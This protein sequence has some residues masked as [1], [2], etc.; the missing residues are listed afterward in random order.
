MALGATEITVLQEDFAGSAVPAQGKSPELALVQDGERGQ[1]LKITRIDKTH[2]AIKLPMT[3]PIPSGHDSIVSFDYKGAGYATILNAAMQQIAGLAFSEQGQVSILST[4]KDTWRKTAMRIPIE[5]WFKV[6]VIFSAAYGS[7][8]LQFTTADGKTLES[9]FAAMISKDAPAFVQ[10]GNTYP[11]GT[12]SYADNVLAT[13]TEE[14]AP[15]AVSEKL[16]VPDGEVLL[17]AA[18]F[19]DGVVPGDGQPPDISIAEMPGKGRVLKFH[20]ST[21]VHNSTLIPLSQPVPKGHDFTLSLDYYGIGYLFALN[22]QK[23]QLAGIVFSSAGEIKALTKEQDF[24]QPTGLLAQHQQWVHA[25]LTFKAADGFYTI[26][27][28]TADGN[29]HTSPPFAASASGE[30]A[31]LRMG[32]SYPIGNVAYA[33]HVIFSRAAAASLDGRE[34]AAENAE[35]TRSTVANGLK[36]SYRFNAPVEVSSVTVSD[37][38]A[39]TITVDGVNVAGHE[40]VYAKPEKFVRTGNGQFQADFEPATLNVLNVTLSGADAEKKYAVG[41]WKHRGTSRAEAD[42]QLAELV[43]GEFKSPVYEGTDDATLAIINN[44]SAAIPASAVLK[45]SWSG[46]IVQP[47]RDINLQPGANAIR[48]PTEAL[49]AGNYFAVVK[50]KTGGEFTRLLR[51][52]VIPAATAPAEINMS[53]IKLYFPDAH[54]LQQANGLEFHSET[55]QAYPLVDQPPAGP[56]EHFRH[57]GN[58]GLKD[59]K[60]YVSYYTVN[61]AFDPR[62]KRDWM[63]TADLDNLEAWDLQPASGGVPPYPS[64]D[65]KYLHGSMVA[66]PQADL[67]GNHV[68]RFHDP[69]TDGPV[70]VSQMEILFV[71][72]AQHAANTLYRNKKVVF[73]EN[74][75]PTA[76]THWA[77]WHKAPGLSLVLGNKPLLIDTYPGEFE[78]GIESNDNFGGQWYSADG[79]SFFYAHGRIVARYA[80][81]QAPF[82]NLSRI[83]RLMTVFRTTDGFNFAQSIIALPGE[84]SPVA[85][86]HYGA[87]F[88]RPSQAPDNFICALVMRYIGIE[89]RWG[90]EIAYSWDGFKWH[91]FPQD[92]LFLPNTPPGTWMAGCI[93]PSMVNLKYQGTFYWLLNWQSS[94]YHFYAEFPEEKIRAVTGEEIKKRFAGRNLERWPLFKHF[95]SDYDKLAA[96]FR[97]HRITPAVMVCRPDGF[98]YALAGESAASFTTIPIHAN[99]KITLNAKIGPNGHIKL[100]LLAAGKEVAST[101]LGEGDYLDAQLFDQ[102]PEGAFT[103]AAE[104]KNTKLYTLGF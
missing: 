23:K 52:Q 68:F 88:F 84:D 90:L 28:T 12:V 79:K 7:F 62:T 86:Q 71:N 50:R 5:Q 55:A 64:E 53:G 2:V 46:K 22:A 102:L 60:L 67:N 37:A 96:D 44:S 94:G 21:K 29:T 65:I 63:A 34:N 32:T 9:D 101:T 18:D 100:R 3:Q 35:I 85:S 70:D 80:P 57:G 91:H 4:A 42:A 61:Q 95:D 49:P 54:L 39:H 40:L 93:H 99:N 20:R 17:F 75:E 97:R 72:N 11:I 43:E 78:T 77:V 10:L 15:E 25:V 38:E 83:L 76:R 98:F 16:T 82:D 69:K 30:C 41:I 56:H 13:Y 36:L 58:M 92:K 48:F 45:E 26:T 19:E 104:L 74:Y 47:W 89:Q 24:F 8:K 33:D 87:L 51:R 27:F 6:K 81:F 66:K 73:G 59:G 31:F 1:V 103:I 14:K